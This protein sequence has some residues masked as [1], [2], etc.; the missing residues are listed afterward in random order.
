MLERI[1]EHPINRIDELLPWNRVTLEAPAAA[2]PEMAVARKAP[3]RAVKTAAP[4]YQLR[5]ELLDVH[6]V[7]WRRVLV[8]ASIKLHKLHGVLLW[9]MGWAGGHLHEFVIGH[10]HYGEPD[11]YFDDPRTWCNETIASRSPPPG[12]SQVLHLPLR[13]WRRLG[14]SGT[15]EKILPAE[16]ALKLPQCLDGANACPPEDVGGRRV[17]RT[18]SRRSG[19]RP[20]KSTPRCSNGPVA[21][22]SPPPSTSTRP[23]ASQAH[24]AIAVQTALT[25]RICSISH[26][27]A[28]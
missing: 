24:Q 8:P 13:L 7:I 4:I 14:A 23:T 2:A 12:R 9:T 20:T 27:W 26:G 28:N 11:P 16:P 5:I 18:S 25:V 6:P 10:D 22:S 17:T 15:V 1:A 3:L 19:I 21:P